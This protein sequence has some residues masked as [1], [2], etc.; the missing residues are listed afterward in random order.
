MLH[1]LD[2]ILTTLVGALTGIVGVI[3]I[4][5]VIGLLAYGLDKLLSLIRVPP[6]IPKLLRW[7]G[8]ALVWSWGLAVVLMVSYTLGES[9]LS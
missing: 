9:I 5:C 7:V 6:S 2:I 3:L 4:L 1:V 8:I